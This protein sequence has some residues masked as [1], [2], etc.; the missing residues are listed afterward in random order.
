MVQLLFG[1]AHT[2]M[3]HKGWSTPKLRWVE[4]ENDID[5]QT[6]TVYNSTTTGWADVDVDGDGMGGGRDRVM[7]DEL[8]DGRII[9]RD[10]RGR[11]YCHV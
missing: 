3:V 1:D 7:K 9:V 2:S 5:Q 11:R 4:F 6:P 8:N 10:E